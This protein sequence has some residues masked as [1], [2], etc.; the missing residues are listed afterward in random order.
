MIDA[1][2]A[3]HAEYFA[4]VRLHESQ[5]FQNAAGRGIVSQIA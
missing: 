2:A 3:A 5:F 1:L 4:P